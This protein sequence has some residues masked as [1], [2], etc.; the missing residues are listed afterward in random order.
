MKPG[1][2]AGAGERDR[3]LMSARGLATNA[4]HPPEREFQ[5]WR[6]HRR[7]GEGSRVAAARTDGGDGGDDLAKLELVEDG[8]LTGGIETNL[9]RWKRR[10]V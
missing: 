1:D 6:S 5:I 4:G 2:R 10:G 3:K 9:R 7:A 8:G